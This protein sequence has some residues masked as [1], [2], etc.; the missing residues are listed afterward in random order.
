M[1]VIASGLSRLCS[2]KKALRLLRSVVPELKVCPPP[3]QAEKYFAHRRFV[4]GRAQLLGYD[5]VSKPCFRGNST[6]FAPI[7]ENGVFEFVGRRIVCVTVSEGMASEFVAL[8]K[9]HGEIGT[10]KDL[11][12]WRNF[13]IN[14]KEA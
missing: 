7:L 4:L 11:A 8:L 6:Q 12:G 1:R 13:S 5:I 10:M 3:R 14:P 2:I 9:E